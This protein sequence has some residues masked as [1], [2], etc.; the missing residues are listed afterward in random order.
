M[1]IPQGNTL[2]IAEHR[3]LKWG[4]SPPSSRGGN[5]ADHKRLHLQSISLPIRSYAANTEMLVIERALA[6]N[7][8]LT[9]V[10]VLDIEAECSAQHFGEYLTYKVTNPSTAA[11]PFH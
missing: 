10:L 7:S 11:T 6:V 8:A 4:S 5:R 1:E 3:T 9:K 2:K